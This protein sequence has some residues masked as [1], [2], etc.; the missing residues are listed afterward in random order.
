[1]LAAAV[2]DAFSRQVCIYVYVEKGN[3]KMK[4]YILDRQ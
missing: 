2:M 1:M 4:T 3:A